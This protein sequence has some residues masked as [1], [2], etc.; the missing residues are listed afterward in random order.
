MQCNSW[1]II[2]ELFEI[3]SWLNRTYQVAPNPFYMESWT[4]H[5]QCRCGMLWHE[6]KIR[7]LKP[8]M[9]PS[10]HVNVSTR[11]TTRQNVSYGILLRFTGILPVPHRPCGMGEIPIKKAGNNTIKCHYQLCAVSLWVDTLPC[12]CYLL[13]CS[14]SSSKSW[15]TLRLLP[16]PPSWLSLYI[17]CNCVHNSV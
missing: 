13:G 7:Q 3:K 17:C 15:D 6:L 10:A 4:N 12:Q 14:P 16:C 5:N 11:V 8:L 1:L 9:W 2:N